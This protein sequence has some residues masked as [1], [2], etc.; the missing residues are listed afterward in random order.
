MIEVPIPAGT[1]TANARDMVIA[2]INAESPL[3]ATTG[4]GVNQVVVTTGT[5]TGAQISTDQYTY[6]R[7]SGATFSSANITAAPN[8]VITG[9]FSVIGGT[10]TIAYSPLPG[11]TYIPSDGR[12][13]F[14]APDISELNIGT[15]LGILTHCWQSI[16]INLD[17]GNEGIACLG[18]RGEREVTIGTLTC[19]VSG[20]VFFSDQE[21]LEA[22]LADRTIGDGNLVLSN[23]IGDQFRFDF[24][25]MKP[26]GGS[27]NAGGRGERLTIPLELQPTPV[28]VCDYMGETWASSLSINPINVA[29]MV[30]AQPGA[31]DDSVI[32][33]FNQCVENIV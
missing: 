7:Y 8:E 13:P 29:P 4:T 11:A 23:S 25:D 22:L 5:L 2:A 31:A 16:T 20:D 26:T 30:M 18:T 21:V 24:F 19:T 28:A 1:T 17:S 14:T 33:R 12:S 10:P 27:L 15:A 6:H 32:V 3:S 9:S